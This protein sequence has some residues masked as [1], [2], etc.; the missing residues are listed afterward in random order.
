MARESSKE[1][2]Q[3]KMLD[4]DLGGLEHRRLLPSVNG[5][6]MREDSPCVQ[7]IPAPAA[8]CQQGML[9]SRFS[10]IPPIPESLLSPPLAKAPSL[11]V[12][13]LPDLPSLNVPSSMKTLPGGMHLLLGPSPLVPSF[14]FL[15]LEGSVHGG[16]STTVSSQTVAGWNPGLASQQLR[17]LFRAQER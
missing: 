17:K 3:A 9:A 7:G 8:S 5:W 10:P 15:H 16:N 14:S 11:H 6:A 13:I 12:Q 4:A 2:E 1:R